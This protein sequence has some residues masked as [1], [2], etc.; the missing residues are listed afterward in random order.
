M[1]NIQLA[2]T[3]VAPTG[4]GKLFKPFSS[5]GNSAVYKED[6][7]SGRAAIVSFKR[8]MPKPNGTSQGVERVEVKLTEYLTVGDI[9]HIIVTSLVSSVP[10]PVTAAQR[11]AQA[12]RIALLAG[13]AVY[14]DTIKEQKIPV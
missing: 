9:E 10:V 13:M 3:L 11:S 1:D 7:P 14:A 12:T 6:S 5:D 4:T 8:V 2:T